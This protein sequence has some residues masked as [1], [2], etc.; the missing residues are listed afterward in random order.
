MSTETV[1]TKRAK[2]L[3]NGSEYIVDVEPYDLLSE[4]L[5]YKIGLTGTKRGC[6]YGGCGTCSVLIDGEA[7]YSCMTPVMRAIG[8]RITTIEGLEEDG[9]LHPVQQAFIDHF[10]FQC[11]YCTPGMIMA[12]VALLNKNRD[13]NEQE[14]R[15][16]LGGVLCRCTGYMKIIESVK[17]AAGTMKERGT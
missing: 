9:K 1:F 6:D 17:A 8:K 14:I 11:G 15:E 2:L 5:R 7:R 12:S 4:V 3:V 13:P 16:G 10:G